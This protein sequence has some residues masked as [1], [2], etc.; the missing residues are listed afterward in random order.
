[1][2]KAKDTSKL[3]EKVFLESKVDDAIK[4]W[5]SLSPEDQKKW[6]AKVNHSGKLD[7]TYKSL[8]GLTPNEA[9]SSKSKMLLAGVLTAFVMNF[10]AG[11]M[12]KAYAGDSTPQ[13]KANYSQQYDG[14]K[15]RADAAF[16]GL[17]DENGS[18]DDQQAPPTK[19]KIGE[20]KVK[21]G[22]DNMKVKKINYE[23]RGGKIIPGEGTTIDDIKNQL[24]KQVDSNKERSEK[25]D[26][27]VW[28]LKFNQQAVR[29]QQQLDSIS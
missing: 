2:S 21:Q 11:A 19:A 23:I 28:K 27:P 26:N 15:D 18:G 13:N 7:D 4:W 3:F 14:V 12:S 20:P 5:K 22:N 1:M 8:F 10:G 25:T 16:Q 9:L 6:M 24:K 17:D 29:A